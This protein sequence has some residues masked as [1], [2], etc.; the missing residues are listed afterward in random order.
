[1]KNKSILRAT[2]IFVGLFVVMAVY[3]A[4]YVG[5]K[6]DEQINNSYNKLAN[7]L[8][9][10]TVRGTIY[11]RNGNVLA[12]TDVDEDGTE[13]RTYPYGD[14]F[15]HVVGMDKYGKSGLEA[16]L[17]IDLLTSDQNVVNKVL[18]DLSGNKYGGN[19]V[20]TTLDADIQNAV[21]NAMKNYNGAVIV[22]DPETGKVLS[23]LSNPAYDPNTVV[24]QWN[25]L[26]NDENSVLLNR[27]TMGL[28][29]PGSIF[30]LFTLEEYLEEYGDDGDYNFECKGSVN[31]SGQV[32][33]CANGTWHGN[34]NLMDSFAHSCNGSFINIGNML[35]DRNLSKL[36]DRMLFNSSLPIQLPYNKSE[37]N[38][39]D[40]DDDVLKAQTYFGQGQTLVTPIHMSLIMNA[41]AN[42]GVIMKPMFVERVENCDNKV[43]KE[44]E[45]EEYKTIF[46]EKETERLIPYLR[47]V[48]TEGTATRL[49]SFKN[50]TVYGKT[51][52]AQID[53]GKTA[54]SWFMGYAAKG[55]RKYSIVV[56]C[57]KVSENTSPA[58]AVTKEILSAL[59]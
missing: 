49:N 34:L 58:I 52:T 24:D 25:L 28:Y 36:C 55:D 21:Y 18:A 57:E 30:K 7:K 12:K 40:D 50:L 48:V 3:F 9:E 54:N 44:Y 29:T 23:M 31:V 39:S 35:G 16:L 42:N 53:N 37:F 43:V 19:N 22:M 26:S 32:I 45:V 15:C 5:V 6:S 20:I 14:V 59:D 38:M 8:S 41:I 10:T 46:T 13:T 51:G 4:Y 2:Y 47:S 27:A 17:N 56:V 1:M 33:K 11:D